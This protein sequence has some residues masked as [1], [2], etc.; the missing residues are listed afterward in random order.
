MSQSLH[1]GATLIL[2]RQG[3]TWRTTLVRQLMGYLLVDVGDLVPVELEAL[4]K[5]T[6]L[7]VR[8]HEQEALL[9][10][11]TTVIGLVEIRGKHLLKLDLPLNLERRQRRK[12]LRVTRRLP[13][14]L[15]LRLKN[16][17]ISRNHAEIFSYDCWV[18]ATAVNV[19]AGG[20]RILLNLPKRHSVL[21]S[22]QVRISCHFDD[23]RLQKRPLKWLRRDS[24]TE[25]VVLVFTFIDL[26]PIETEQLE[27]Q[28]LRW[29]S[30]KRNL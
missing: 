20:L 2:D 28:N 22:D 26:N 10:F 29:L 15:F 16:D 25:D 5:G 8:S 19:S 7:T 18:E 24:S 30:A 1:E 13:V 14:Q 23:L 4:K 11:E 17:F 12:H 27:K 6:F 21:S 9:L 3:R